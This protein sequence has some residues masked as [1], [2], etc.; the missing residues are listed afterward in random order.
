MTDRR[1]PHATPDDARWFREA[2]APVVDAQPAWYMLS[3]FE[4][5]RAHV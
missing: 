1:D 3:V 2:V 4:I 5:G